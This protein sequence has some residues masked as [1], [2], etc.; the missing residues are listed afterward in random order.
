MKKR[1]YIIF[2]FC[3]LLGSVSA[4]RFLELGNDLIRVALKSLVD[5]NDNAL[6]AAVIERTLTRPGRS[7]M[8]QTSNVH[9]E[10]FCRYHLI[11]IKRCFL[12]QL[13]EFAETPEEMIFAKI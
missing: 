8:N 4:Q 2:L 5:A 10:V 13:Q 3:L 9:G 11:I 6:R 1:S 7:H 12:P